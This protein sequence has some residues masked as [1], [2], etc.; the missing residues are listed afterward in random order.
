MRLK[1]G[2]IFYLFLILII[3]YLMIEMIHNN[4]ILVIFNDSA[5]AYTEYTYMMSA[6]FFL[7]L[8]LWT[9]I[10]PAKM[11]TSEGPTGTN[12]KDM[13]KAIFVFLI[14]IIIDALI[15]KVGVDAILPKLFGTGTQVHKTQ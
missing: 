11:L 15:I 10:P 9:I 7:M 1:M 4:L 6:I 13:I 12:L 3:N 5:R 2:A 14:M 8:I